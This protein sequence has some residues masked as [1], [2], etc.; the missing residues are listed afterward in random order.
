MESH[1]RSSKKAELRYFISN[2]YN[3]ELI[4]EALENRWHIENGLH[5]EKDMF[6]NEDLFRSSETNTVKSLAVINNF[7]MQ[8]IRIYQIVSGLELRYAKIYMRHYPIEGCVEI[9][10]NLKSEKVTEKIRQ[11]MIKIKKLGLI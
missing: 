1:T 7:A 8:L 11:E 4:C 10:A 6:L 9:L 3:E 2:T 5:R